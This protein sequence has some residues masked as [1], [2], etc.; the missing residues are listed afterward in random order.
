MVTNNKEFVEFLC[1]VD[2]TD[3]RER[4]WVLSAAAFLAVA[5]MHPSGAPCL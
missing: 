3:K 2:G 4:P 1:G 5:V